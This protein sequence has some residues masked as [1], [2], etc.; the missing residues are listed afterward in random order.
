MKELNILRKVH[1]NFP[2]RFLPV[3]AV[4]D[5]ERESTKVRFCLDAKRRYKGVSFNDYLH[6]GNMETIDIFE[7]L[8]AFRSGYTAL[9]G[10]IKKMFWQI[11]LSEY[12][13][14]FHGIIYKG[15]TYVFTRVCFGDKPSP[16]IANSCMK[17]IAKKE[18][19]EF[20]LGSW[21]ITN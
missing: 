19:E 20:P 2:K 14:Q 5:L 8:T 9:Q 3:L 11:S 4:V 18:K 15:E 7:L 10:D 21:L 16:T 13:Q 12:D 17:E 6:K 1:K